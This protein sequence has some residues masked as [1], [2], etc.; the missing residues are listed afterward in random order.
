[1]LFSE[2][3][4]VRTAIICG[5]L[6]TNAALAGCVHDQ[7]P[8]VAA[9][10]PPPPPEPVWSKPGAS[11]DEFHRTKAACLLRLTEFQAAN[12]GNWSALSIFP[13]CMRANGWVQVPKNGQASERAATNLTP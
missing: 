2:G 7:A 3:G 8:A 10:P 13:V 9:A 4:T 5:A 12:P 11:N 1:M 6:M